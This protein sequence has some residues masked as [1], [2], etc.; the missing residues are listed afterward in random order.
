MPLLEVG[1]V[2]GVCVHTH[3]VGPQVKEMIRRYRDGDLDGARALDE[4]LRPAIEL[5]RVQ[6]N[7]I[8]I[9]RALDLLGLASGHR[10]ASSRRGRRGGDGRRPQT[11][12]SASGC[13]HPSQPDR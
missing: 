10:A 12:W 13:C 11:A 7:P 5:L 8:A 2:G 9:K 6:T 4:E 1:G 3:V